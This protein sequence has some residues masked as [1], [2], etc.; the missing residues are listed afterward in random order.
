MQVMEAGPLLE[1]RMPLQLHG[2]TCGHLVI[3]LHGVFKYLHT[4]DGTILIHIWMAYFLKDISAMAIYTF[5]GIEYF[6]NIP[7]ILTHTRT[8]RI[9]IPIVSL[10]VVLSVTFTT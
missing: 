5:P 9:K 10:L 1:P 6:L 8:H 2:G 7:K 3:V 4:R